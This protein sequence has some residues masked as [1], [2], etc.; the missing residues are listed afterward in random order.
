MHERGSGSK[1]TAGFQR[2]KVAS[3]RFWPDVA[4]RRNQC[5]VHRI[6]ISRRRAGVWIEVWPLAPGDGE[7]PQNRPNKGSP[8]RAARQKRPK[9]AIS[10][11]GRS[12]L[13]SSLPF[14]SISTIPTP[15]WRPSPACSGLEVRCTSKCRTSK[16]SSILRVIFTTGSGGQ[17]DHPSVANLPALSRFR[18][19][20]GSFA[21]AAAEDN[22]E[23]RIWR[24]WGGG[25]GTPRVEGA[26]GMIE[27][28][29]SL[30]VVCLSN[31]GSLGNFIET[32]AVRG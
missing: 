10:V 1:R 21:Y 19:R 11:P 9:S 7:R 31:I 24:V 13:W 5:G 4:T 30:A 20:S 23:P 12:M 27:H 28:V 15:L 17:A 8:T 14:S 22:L 32:W 16:V 18:L 26:R 25:F 29:A 2:M 3:D 6:Q